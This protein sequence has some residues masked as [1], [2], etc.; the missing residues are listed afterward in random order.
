MQ[1]SLNLLGDPELTL[2][3]Q[4]PSTLS[5]SYAGSISIGSQT[6][7]VETGVANALVALSKGSEV[8]AYGRADGSGH[9]EASISPSTEGTMDVTVTA[10]KRF[11]HRIVSRRSSAAGS[12]RAE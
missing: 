1:F 9:F 10:Q 8:Y 12:R 4:D 5:P 6:Y 11:P 2:Y 7:A 3:T